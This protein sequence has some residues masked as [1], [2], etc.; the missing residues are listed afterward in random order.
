MQ[1]LKLLSL[2]KKLTRPELEGFHK[3][4]KQHHS[5]EKIGLSVFEYLIR[6]YPDFEPPEK[7]Q[8]DYACQKIFKT[9]FEQDR[10]ARKKL[11][12]TASDLYKW[13]QHFLVISKALH[14]HALQQTIWL[15]ILQEKGLTEEFSRK[16]AKFYEETRNAP[17]KTPADALPNWMASYFQR[18]QL[19]MDK[20]LAHVALIQQCTETMTNCQEIIRLRMACEMSLV[21]KVTAKTLPDQ[22]GETNGSRQVGLSI[23]KNTYETLWRLT[24]TAEASHFERL[25]HLLI[26]HGHEIDTQ[27]LEWIIQYAYN[28]AA[29]QSRKNTDPRHTVRMHHLNKISLEQGVFFRNGYLPSST[30][31]NMVTIACQARDFDWASRFIREYSHVILENKRQDALL[32]A[33]AVFA[34]ESGKYQDAVNLLKPA[35]FESELDVFRAKS[36]LLR[37]YYE[38]QTEQDIIQDACLQLENW[39]RRSRESAAVLALKAFVLILKMI[40]AQKSSKRVILDRLEKAP[41]IYSK[42]WLLEKTATYTPKYSMR[43]RASKP[44]ARSEH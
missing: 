27:E 37:S 19:S 41:A 21:Q 44:P 43:Y 40:V 9:D 12:N 36:I 30:F 8:L 14:N 7:L 2:L 42:H 28:F 34:F 31:G 26:Q 13:L 11:L 33:Q 15:S 1:H 25:E 17:F 3:Y 32:L 6:F 23:L 39:L 24:E 16:A 35:V 4:L 5:R 29:H 18:E 22:T 20:P 10:H 38:L